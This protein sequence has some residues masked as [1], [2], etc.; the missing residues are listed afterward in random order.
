MS[1]RYLV[2]IV[3]VI[4]LMLPIYWLVNMSFKTTNEIL[5]SKNAEQGAGRFTKCYFSKEAL[6]EI[7]SVDGKWREETMALPQGEA[8]A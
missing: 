4:F 8:T 2:P 6:K 7:T 5:I 1:K 3:Y